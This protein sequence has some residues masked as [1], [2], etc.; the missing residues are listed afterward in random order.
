[1]MGASKMEAV[2]FPSD[3]VATNSC[4][5][6]RNSGPKSARF[7]ITQSTVQSFLPT[8]Q[9]ASASSITDDQASQR[10]LCI[11]TSIC[12]PAKDI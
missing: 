10:D 8:L 11:V 3:L 5:F 12:N 2:A 6:W 1:M 4:V 9:H 7:E